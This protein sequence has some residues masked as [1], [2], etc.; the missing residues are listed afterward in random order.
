MSTSGPAGRV[1]HVRRVVAAALAALLA[2]VVLT[3]D[4]TLPHARA[5]E[6]APPWRAVHYAGGGVGDGGP[7][8]DALA[9]P[10]WRTVVTLPRGELAWYDHA[11][12]Q[13]RVLD[14]SGRVTD[15]YGSGRRGDAETVTTLH[16]AYARDV[17]L[18]APTDMWS[19]ADGALWLAYSLH[20]LRIDPLTHRV[21]VRVVPQG[22]GGSWPLLVRYDGSLVLA[23]RHDGGIRTATLP[24]GWTATTP[25]RTLLDREP[26][27]FAET[28]GGTLYEAYGAGVYRH[29]K[30]LPV[31]VAGTTARWADTLERPDGVP[32]VGA[33]M[34][35]VRLG[36]DSTGRIAVLD[37]LDRNQYVLRVVAGAA[38]TV[39]TVSEPWSTGRND[40]CG[41][42]PRPLLQATT[43][44]LACAWSL[45]SYRVDGAD[46]GGPGTPLAGR[47][48]DVTTT[49]ASPP[50]TAPRQAYLSSTS[51]DLQRSPS[52]GVAVVSTTDVRYMGEDLRRQ[53]VV[54]VL[55]TAAEAAEG[56]GWTGPVTWRAAVVGVGTVVAVVCRDVDTCVLRRREPFATEWST[57][58]WPDADVRPAARLVVPDAKLRRVYLATGYDGPLE[59]L[60]LTT[61]TVARADGIGAPP[62]RV[63]V[64]PDGQV[65]LAVEGSETARVWDPASGTESSTGVPVGIGWSPSLAPRLVG[66]VYVST[67]A[68]L[69]PYRLDGTVGAAL[70]PALGHA[71]RRVDG[72]SLDPFPP[73]LH[74]GVSEDL[75]LL[76]DQPLDTTVSRITL[77]PAPPA[78]PPDVRVVR[79]DGQV[80]V[81]WGAVDTRGATLYGY[82]VYEDGE[83]YSSTE[84]PATQRSVVLSAPNGVPVRYTVVAAS[85]PG[86]GESSLLTPWVVPFDDVPPGRVGVGATSFATDSVTL[87]WTRPEDPDTADVIVARRQGPDAAGCLSS[88]G[89]DVVYRG[90]GTWVSVRVTPGTTYSFSL[91][92]RDRAGNLG[93]TSVVRAV[94]TRATISTVL[95]GR[96]A[97]AV[98]YGTTQDVAHTVSLVED[99]GVPVHGVRV[100]L[101]GRRAGSGAA[102]STLAR[103]TTYLG[104]AQLRHRPLIGTEYRYVFAGGDG[105]T[106]A[107]SPVRPLAVRTAVTT[108]LSTS[109]ARRG[110]TATL[111]GGVAPNH[112]GLPVRLQVKGS[113]GWTTVAQQTLSSS[114]TY[115]FT[116]SRS[117]SS[118][119]ATLAYRVVP[120]PRAGYVAGAGPSRSIRWT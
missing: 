112:A 44:L 18:P 45:R 82:R 80:T 12:E 7:G 39:R 15:L 117:R 35:P 71:A 85:S 56:L 88:P 13:I 90:T 9:R 97:S 10:G 53:D 120:V 83:P 79:G 25:L 75:F 23:E 19:T 103:A 1:A 60:D 65:L 94:G 86:P 43:V 62:H 96:P 31:L 73:V 46:A 50:G 5:A 81:S 3:A 87:R 68:T 58:P 113:S 69:R 33:A 106:G 49:V 118:S 26:G 66:W 111:S 29:G 48:E 67:G 108:A 105:R 2:V 102:W 8:T 91:C 54:S 24:A 40:G 27:V 76:G 64:M 92:A 6:A 59:Y 55:A 22:S 30:G 104:T 20:V 89:T 38:A 36:V 42:E 109:T 61:G 100:S 4:A 72:P 110:T 70:D 37:R 116:V 101:Q 63:A 119:A 78:A 95:D 74:A 16:G 51:Y 28:P 114:S 17:A 47:G 77:R 32:A 99:D 115:R 93:P 14:S 21:S 107:V 52:G 41:T 34:Q 57:V 11:S 98:T 84:I